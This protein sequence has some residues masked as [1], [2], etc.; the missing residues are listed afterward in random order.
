[1]WCT[2]GKRSI[3]GFTEKKTTCWEIYRRIMALTRAW[4]DGWIWY[5]TSLKRGG[6]A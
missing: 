3:E 6:N 4:E 1:M 5:K 2:I